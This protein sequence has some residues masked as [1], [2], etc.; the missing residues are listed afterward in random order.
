MG[1]KQCCTVI[2][3]QILLQV[4]FYQEYI[5]ACGI[6][7]DLM[8]SHIERDCIWL[9]HRRACESN[10]WVVLTD[11]KRL[12]GLPIPPMWSLVSLRVEGHETPVVT[13]PAPLLRGRFREPVE[14]GDA[15]GPVSVFTEIFPAQAPAWSVATGMMIQ[16]YDVTISNEAHFEEKIDKTNVV[17]YQNS[18]FWRTFYFWNTLERR[19]LART[20]AEAKSAAYA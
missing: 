2:V 12:R 6:I 18:K 19:T 20:T 13:V 16:K 3:S 4:I 17:S 5:W 1:I 7:L 8:M 14:R 11:E 15:G 9:L 10:I